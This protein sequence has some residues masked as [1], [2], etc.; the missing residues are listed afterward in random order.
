M[1]SRQFRTVVFEITDPSRAQA[2]MGPIINAMGES[3][4]IAPGVRVSAVS[5]RDEISA[6]EALEAGMPTASVTVAV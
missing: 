5:M 4:D 3:I 6:I 2:F 1:P